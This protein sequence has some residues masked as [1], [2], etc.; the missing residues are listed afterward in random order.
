MGRNSGRDLEAVRAWDVAPPRTPRP[1]LRA[2]VLD[3]ARLARSLPWQREQIASDDVHPRWSLRSRWR[4]L[5]GV[6]EYHWIDG[7][8]LQTVAAHDR[9][10]D[11]PRL[12]VLGIDE[13]EHVPAWVAVRAQADEIRRALEVG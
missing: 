3:Y 12:E 13:I 6:G 1:E 5:I 10:I 9:L 8:P 2:A 11:S 4:A 7:A